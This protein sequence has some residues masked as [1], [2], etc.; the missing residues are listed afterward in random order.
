MSGAQRSA[1]QERLTMLF[2]WYVRFSN[3]FWVLS[4]RAI[5]AASLLRITACEWRGLPNALRCVVQLV[6]VSQTHKDSK[7]TKHTEDI[8]QRSGVAIVQTN[9][10]WP[11]ARDWSCYN[12][13]N[14]L[15]L[16]KSD[17]NLALAWQIFHCLQGPTC[18]RRV[19]LHFRR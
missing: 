15:G 13:V 6:I 4:T 16:R 5:I 11:I 17:E 10:T 12:A 8:L 7:G 9:N 14:D 2:I 3:Q 19:L 18:S 1:I